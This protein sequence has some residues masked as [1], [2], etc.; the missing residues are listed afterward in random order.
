MLYIHN[1]IVVERASGGRRNKFSNKR[2]IAVWATADATSQNVGSRR[3]SYYTEDT[4]FNYVAGVM[5]SE[6]R[7]KAILGRHSLVPKS[8]RR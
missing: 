1:T 8:R 6:I 3:A 4:D 2:V 7:F 5:A